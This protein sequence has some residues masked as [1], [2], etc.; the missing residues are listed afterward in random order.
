MRVLDTVRKNPVAGLCVV[1]AGICGWVAAG[2]LNAPGPQLVPVSGNEVLAPQINR[3][4]AVTDEP[5]IAENRQV[6]LSVLPLLKPGMTRVEVEGMIGPPTAKSLHPVVASEGRL[7]YRTAYE[8][9]EP[10]LATIRPIQPRPRMLPRPPET[11]TKSL[12]AME[13]DASKPGHPLLE[14]LY[15]DPLF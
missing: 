12:V 15:L 2:L 7:T 5:M 10:D 9:T 1:F 11:K 8:L 6:S 13:Y 3:V 4:A 14:I